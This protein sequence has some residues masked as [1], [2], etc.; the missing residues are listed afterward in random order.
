MIIDFSVMYDPLLTLQHT[1]VH[2]KFHLFDIFVDSN[3]LTIHKIFKYMD[4]TAFLLIISFKYVF[5]VN[6]SYEGKNKLPCGDKTS[7]I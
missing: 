4:F 3:R 5:C 7:A 2:L 1:E 6:S